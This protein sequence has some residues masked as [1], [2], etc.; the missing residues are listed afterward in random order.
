MHEYILSAIA[1]STPIL[2]AGTMTDKP[3]SDPGDHAVDFSRRYFQEL[4]IYCGDR[5]DQ[6]G[7]PKG[8]IGSSDRAHNIEWCAFNPYERDGGG[9]S[10][11]G[12]INVDSGVLNP[13]WNAARIGPRARAI[14]EKSRLRDRIDAAIVHE[15]EEHRCG[16]HEQ[17][18]ERAP[19]TDLPVGG[20]ARALLRA[21]RLG[22]QSTRGGD[23][24]LG[25]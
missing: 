23:P 9:L 8:Q 2:Y 17:A 22:E 19:E 1:L 3:P 21:I 4:D 11:G 18:V 10:T 6:L 16:S 20:R 15:F 12:R 25:R 7:I 5:M 24:S 14:W 13:G